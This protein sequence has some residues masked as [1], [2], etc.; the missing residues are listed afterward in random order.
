MH[1]LLTATVWN[2]LGDKE[3]GE[4]LLKEVLEMKDQIKEN[5]WVFP[6]AHAELADLYYWAGKK[7]AAEAQLKM[8]LKFKDY[9]WMDIVQNRMKMALDTLHKEMKEKKEKEGER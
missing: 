6:N 2:G 5:V 8:G 1:K 7:S 9:E 4:Q 3:K